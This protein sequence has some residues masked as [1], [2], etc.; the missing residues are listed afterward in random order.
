MAPSVFDS[1]PQVPGDVFLVVASVLW[2]RL[3]TDDRKAIRASCRSGR[4][5][6]DS[7]LKKLNLKLGVPWRLRHLFDEELE[8]EPLT[9]PTPSELRTCVDG[10]LQRGARLQDVNLMFEKPWLEAPLPPQEREEQL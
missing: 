10:V 1:F 2:Q 8:E 4:R 6:H 9:A 7:L 3:P 5:M